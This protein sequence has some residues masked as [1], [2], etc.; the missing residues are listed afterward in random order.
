MTIEEAREW[1]N[2]PEAKAARAAAEA[3]KAKQIEEQRE[4]GQQWLA[5]CEAF[6]E[7]VK[8]YN[9]EHVNN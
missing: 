8:Q 6:N 7:Y 1:L 9:E 4:R 5:E 2:S 3:R